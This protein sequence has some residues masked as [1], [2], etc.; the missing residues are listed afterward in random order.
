MVSACA[1]CNIMELWA[2]AFTGTVAGFVY[3]GASKAVLKLQID[4][5]LDAIA[6]H[7]GG[8]FWGLISATVVGKGGVVYGIAAAVNHEGS[9]PVAQA[10]AVSS[11]DFFLKLGNFSVNESIF[12]TNEMVQITMFLSEMDYF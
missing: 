11:Y 12:S 2:A 4:D 8:G 3:M 10:F 5:P 7:A 6:V 9:A 1:G